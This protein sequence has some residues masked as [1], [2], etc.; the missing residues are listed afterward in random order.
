[1][2][3]RTGVAVVTFTAVILAGCSGTSQSN[4][5]PSAASNGAAVRPTTTYTIV[6]LGPGPN[7]KD[8][9]GY[10]ESPSAQAGTYFDHTTSCGKD[11]S[12]KVYYPLAWTGPGSKPVVILPTFYVEGWAYGAGGSSIVGTLITNDG[13][14]F[15]YNHAALWQGSSYK[16]TDLNPSGSCGSCQPGSNAYSTNGTYIAGSGGSPEHALLWKIGQLKAP[17][18][19]NPAGA[20]YSEAYALNATGQVGYAYLTTTNSDHA[21]LWNGTA[22]SAVDL[23]PSPLTSA[24]A[25]GLGYKSEVGCGTPTGMSVTHAL[26]W[27]GTAASMV[28]LQPSGFTDSCARAAHGNIQVGYGHVNT[29]SVLH[30]LLWKGRAKSALD[31]QTF[32]PSAFTSSEA[33]AIDSTGAILGSAYDSTTVTWHAVMWVP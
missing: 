3:A 20:S 4:L 21:I 11:C 23:T 31:L 5:T 6:D 1:M 16:F 17:V 24:Y 10:A 18:D 2:D 26:L 14:Y 13:G 29:T 33:Y 25:T 12:S 9:Y 22:A 19:L 32:L 27:R 15:G 8:A 7:G 28:D 30:A